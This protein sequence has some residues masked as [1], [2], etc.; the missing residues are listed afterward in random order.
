[1]HDRGCPRSTKSWFSQR[2]KPL[3]I[4]AE[5]ACLG[6][7]PGESSHFTNRF[8]LHYTHVMA[9]KR[10]KNHRRVGTAI[11]HNTAHDLGMEQ[12]TEAILALMTIEGIEGVGQPVMLISPA[13]LPLDFLGLI[14]RLRGGTI[15]VDDEML[16]ITL[17]SGRKQRRARRSAKQRLREALMLLG[18][19]AIDHGVVP[20]DVL[21]VFDQTKHKLSKKSTSPKDRK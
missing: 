16:L 20:D 3:T 11:H 12:L 19:H 8:D 9:K 2:T 18:C 14:E 1:M 15:E 21:A 6:S 17:A 5:F 10:D 13:D 4:G 7:E